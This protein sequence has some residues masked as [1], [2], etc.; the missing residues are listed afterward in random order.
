MAAKWLTGQVRAVRPTL[1][2][3]C[4]PWTPIWK[5]SPSKL[6]G[7]KLASLGRP[8][9][10]A[11]TG[12]QLDIDTAHTAPQHGHRNAHQPQD[13]A[14]RHEDVRGRASRHEYHIRIV[15]IILVTISPF[16]DRSIVR[17][18]WLF[19]CC[20]IFHIPFG[21]NVPY[22]NKHYYPFY[23]CES[24]FHDYSI[25]IVSRL[26]YYYVIFPFL[27]HIPIVYIYIYI[28]T[29]ILYVITISS[30]LSHIIFYYITYYHYHIIT[31]IYDHTP[32]FLLI[33]LFH[34][35]IL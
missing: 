24:M 23:R 2:S 11:S 1:C 7:K 3:P 30:L 20:S 21:H 29:T 12:T 18:L 26:V 34:S 25:T 33:I 17:I 4:L 14:E 19:H 32:V 22:I 13:N 8:A 6:H 15:H 28:I 35:T 16:Y 31:I 10:M 27:Y 9:I 5:D